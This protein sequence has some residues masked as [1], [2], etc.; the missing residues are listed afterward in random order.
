LAKS[1][2]VEAVNKR[3]QI[4]AVD[5]KFIRPVSDDLIEYLYDLYAGQIRFVMDSVNTVVANLPQA[6]AQTLDADSARVFLA[7][8]V[9]ERIRH[10]LTKREWEVLSTAVKLDDFTNTDIAAALGQ[11]QQNVTKY[12]N[13]LLAKNFV[14]PYR[15]DGRNICY[16]ASEDVRVIRDVPESE[17]TAL[18]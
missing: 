5:G 17:Q 12:L 14:Y 9:F 4:L 8:L 7:R 18:F 10:Q 2:V 6:L 11:R 3:Y 16:R 15:R 13:T 1:Q